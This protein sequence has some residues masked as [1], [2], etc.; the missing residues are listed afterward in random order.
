MAKSR[1]IKR[2]IKAVGNIKRITKTM[3]MIATARFQ[4]AQRR[5]T[6]SRPYS[7]KIAELVGELAAM[8]AES[9]GLDHPLLASE[10]PKSNRHLLLVITSNRGLCGGYN[11]NILRVAAA[12]LREIK[13]AGA[14]VDLELVGKKGQAFFKFINQPISQFYSEFTDRPTFDQVDKLAENYMEQYSA[15]TYDSVSVVYMSFVSIARQVA[16]AQQL[17]PLE[18]PAAKAAEKAAA[19]SPTAAA[20][21]TA[22]AG[23]TVRPVYDFSPSP[24][25][26]LNELLPATVKTTLFQA[27]NEAVVGEQI[28]RMVAMKAAT[29]A[30]GKMNKE[31]TRRYNRARQSAI[32]TELTEIIAGAASLE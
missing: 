9:G 29:D 20:G 1:E 27:F 14:T 12:K 19:A 7:L 22:P 26:L 24:M 2:R 5:A 32:T 10:R 6:A 3:Q 18:N 30:S 31:L 21:R 23:P 25:E 11:G 4:A 8:A 17:L 13:G 16:K 15:G 28:A